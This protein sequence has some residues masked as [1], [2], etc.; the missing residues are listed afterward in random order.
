MA[1]KPRILVVD[2]DEGIRRFLSEALSAE[3]YGVAVTQTAEEALATVRGQTHD[4]AI[5]E[6]FLRGL[7][8][9]ELI[10]RL[11]DEHRGVTPILM[12][13]DAPIRTVV[14]G[15]RAGAVDCLEKPIDLDRLRIAV[16]NALG[17]ARL[18]RE[19]VALRRQN[20]AVSNGTEMVVASEA[21]REVARLCDLIAPTDL[22]V[23][24]YGESGTGKE[25]V[26]TR[27]HSRSPRSA[28]PFIAINC[29]AIQ[30]GLLESELFGHAKGSYTAAVNERPGLFEIADRGTL[31]LDEI[32]EMPPDLQV[33]LLRVL[34]TSELRRVGGQ[35]TIRVD[36][37]IIA[38]TNKR[39]AEE[40]RRGAFREDLY[41]RLNV[42]S[43]EVPPLRKRPE[44]IPALV[45]TFSER[46]RRHGVVRRRFTPE[47]IEV[48][49][50]YPWPGNVRELE[51]LVER[52]LILSRAE[53]IGPNDLPELIKP[54]E[55]AF[56]PVGEDAD[57]TLEQLERR[58]ILRA[59]RK[60]KGNKV[61]TARKLGINVKTL[62][63]KIKA[64]ELED[65]VAA[66]PV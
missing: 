1:R 22:T 17:L 59:L 27:V 35:R 62:Y 4:V 30:P 55:G 8:G 58:H 48:L 15:M 16:D 21:T 43:I 5:V 29:G 23:L 32:G 44:E 12:T 31:F 18:E 2:G 25:L 24:V 47:A 41:Y 20:Q 26:A 54:G 13:R 37:R 3:G 28:L 50:S 66:E 36:V 39:L 64:Y 38:A 19:N 51:N 40:V 49:Q 11:R 33:K 53:E 14:S 9:I 7:S 61:R 6:V 65:G 57:L 34:E 56:E 60:N 42:I 52:A 46:A 45:E 63:N 10:K